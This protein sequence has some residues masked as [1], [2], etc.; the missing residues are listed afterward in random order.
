MT[1][2]LLFWVALL[3]FVAGST[4]IWLGVKNA[5]RLTAGGTDNPVASTTPVAGPSPNNREDWLTEYELTERSGRKFGSH[6]LE[7]TIHVVSFF[8]AS[9]PGSCTTQ[10]QVFGGLERE[11]GKQGVK[12]VAITCDPEVDTP[13]VLRAYADQR[14]APK[15]TWLFLTGELDY[16]RRVAAEIYGVALD[17]QVH[18]EKFLL[19]DE[20]GKIRGQY[21]WADSKKL[22]ELK[23]DLRTLL[24][25]KDAQTLG[26]IREAK[27]RQ[28][29]IAELEEDDE[30]ENDE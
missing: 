5:N 21:A 23:A 15:D 14:R 7:G 27:L 25:D 3:F 12:F 9:C 22:N 4:L 16:I 20:S 19:V 1:R 10:N 13:D 2:M 26:E 30:E 11:F 18:V 24:A 6:D 28:A 8:F 29:R 17:R